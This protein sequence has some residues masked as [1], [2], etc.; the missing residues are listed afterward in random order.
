MEENKIKYTADAPVGS[1]TPDEHLQAQIKA[2]EKRKE[3][4]AKELNRK[5]ET[6]LQERKEAARR[7]APLRAADR[8]LTAATVLF[9]GYSLLLGG[10]W[11]PDGGM[12]ARILLCLLAGAL[13]GAGLIRLIGGYSVTAVRWLRRFLLAVSMAVTMINVD[14][15]LGAGRAVVF[16]LPFAILF[17]VSF[18]FETMLVSFHR[19]RVTD[20]GDG[21]GTSRV[22]IFACAVVLALGAGQAAVVG[23]AERNLPFLHN[24]KS[25]LRGGRYGYV[26]LDGEEAVELKRLYRTLYDVKPV[27]G[28]VGG[29]L[30]LSASEL[31]GGFRFSPVRSVG[32][33]AMQGI[34]TYSSLRLSKWVVRIERGALAESG[35]NRVISEGYRLHVADGFADSSVAELILENGGVVEL[36]FGSAPRAGLIIRVPEALLEAYRTAYP[37]YAAWFEKI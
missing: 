2:L 15:D 31:A 23:L 19:G 8:L 18:F 24:A 1:V 11:D 9:S 17:A 27:L 7:H 33:G 3:A 26:T 10:F 28:A 36:S 12:V 5:R 4:Y 30:E 25:T 22:A 6:L 37:A 34:H 32:E 21:R 14:T 29:E 20:R 16:Y 13:A 35:F